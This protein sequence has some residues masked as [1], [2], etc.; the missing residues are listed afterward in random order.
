MSAPVPPSAPVALTA[1]AVAT[2]A[3][4]SGSLVRLA[5]DIPTLDAGMLLQ[6]TVQGRAGPGLTVLDTSLGRM[7][8]QSTVAPP[9]GST[10]QLQ[11]V[12]GGATPQ[13]QFN[14]LPAATSPTGAP[15]P[16]AAVDLSIASHSLTAR[17]VATGNP[18]PTAAASQTPQATQP[19]TAPTLPLPVGSNVTIRILGVLPSGSTGAVAGGAVLATIG[20]PDPGGETLLQT[21]L[22][23]LSAAL[24]YPPPPGSVLRLSVEGWSPPQAASLPNLSAAPQWQALADALTA[25][26]SADPAAAQTLSRAI[27]QPGAGLSTSILFF[28]SALS[29]GDIRRWIGGDALRG[30]ERSGSIDRIRSDF[31]EIR[32]MSREPAGQDWRLFLIPL[33]TDQGLDQLRLF[34]RDERGTDGDD[35]AEPGTRFVL[36]ITLSKLGRMQFDG[37]MRQ[38]AVRL[39]LRTEAPLAEAMRQ[40]IRAL[41]LDTL[42]A[43]GKE[44]EIAFHVVRNFP[45][46]PMPEHGGTGVVVTI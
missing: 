9:A 28:L 44:G 8:M 4:G 37:L 6:A 32:R 19:G 40:D 41:Y 21:P 5:P 24:R 45:V 39:I 11:V 18:V 10:I 17:V 14:L 43:L 16:A 42:S 1:L 2:G 20:N 46:N 15:A 7:T 38:K 23:T 13:V 3:A 31:G 30:L 26:R 12:T 33:M 25:L 35:A 34:L 36:D 22:G 27:P 29:T